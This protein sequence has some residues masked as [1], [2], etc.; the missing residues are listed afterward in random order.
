MQQFILQESVLNDNVLSLPSEGK[1]FKG[2]YVAVIEEW[3]YKNAW[4]NEL[5]VKKFRSTERLEKY[6]S[7]NYPS[8]DL[9]EVMAR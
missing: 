6:I 4:S 7:K 5:V 1:V 9:Y 3:R 8:F 2:N